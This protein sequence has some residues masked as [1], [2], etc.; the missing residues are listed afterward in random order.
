MSSPICPDWADID[1]NGNPDLAAAKNAANTRAA[2]MRAVYGRG[3]VGGGPYLDKTWKEQAPRCL[4]AGIERRSAYLFLCM[5]KAGVHTPSPEDQADALISQCP[6]GA[7][8]DCIRPSKD[9]VVFVDVEEQSTLGPADYYNWVL[10]AVVRLARYYGA[11]PGIYC[12]AHIWAEYLGNHAPGLLINCPL[13]IAKPWPYAV[14]TQVHLDG[15]PAWSPI[16]MPGFDNRWCLY[17]AQGDAIGWPGFP[18]TVDMSRIRVYGKGSTGG[19]TVWTQERLGVTADGF[20]G[21]ITGA[22]VGAL[23]RA[24]GLADDQIVGADTLAPLMWSRPAP[25][26]P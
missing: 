6:M 21:P 3:G 10:R 14:N 2:I 16:L 20:Y 13:W 11:W 12:A 17:Q 1:G 19:Q 25:V 4:A 22:A 18:H 26:P 8:P 7:G 9:Y 23:Q 5:P 24:N 15:L